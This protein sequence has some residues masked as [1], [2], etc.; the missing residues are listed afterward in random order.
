MTT[1]D[2]QTS[3]RIVNVFVIRCL[4]ASVP[5]FTSEQKRIPP[6]VAVAT[7]GGIEDSFFL[8]FDTFHSADSFHRCSVL[9]SRPMARVVLSG[10]KTPTWAP[11]V[12]L[13]IDS[14]RSPV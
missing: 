10:A 3:Q 1:N 7:F 13:L 5:S 2:Q 6:R 9:S 8:I 14:V 12:L 11:A 4:N